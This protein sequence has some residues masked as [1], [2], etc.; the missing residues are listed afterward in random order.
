MNED[1]RTRELCLDI[2]LAVSRGEEHSHVLIKGVLDKYDDW[3]GSRKAFLKK[4]TMGVLERK[5]ELDYV[6]SRF[7]STP[8]SKLKPVIRTIL[9]IGIYQILY[10]DSV[11]DTKAVNLSVELAKKRGPKQLSGFVNGV[12]R[13]VSRQK[14][15]IVFP[16]KSENPVLYLS[17]KYSVPEWIVKEIAGQYG[18]ER[19]ETMFADSLNEAPIRVH[20]RSILSDGKKQ[21]LLEAW[22]EAGIEVIPCS[23][24]PDAYTLKNAESISGVKGFSEGYFQVQDF[25]S[26]LSG[27]LAPLQAGDLV[28]DVCAA[29]GGKSIY[30]ADK[31]E[32]LESGRSEKTGE[33]ERGRVFA[34]D[35]SG[36]KVGK[37]LENAERMRIFNISCE[38]RDASVANPAMKNKADLLIADV[39]CSGLGVIG[40][41]PD[42]KYRLKEQ[43]FKEIVELQKKI[44]TEAVKDVKNGGYFLY[45]TCTV[46]QGENIDM[47]RWMCENLPL[48][49]TSFDNL[50]EELKDS[51]VSKGCVQLISGEHDCDGFFISLL[52]RIQ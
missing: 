49:E 46:N 45:S 10:M 2:L 34:Y 39:P 47:V 48:E 36:S 9:E 16:E 51:L 18:E 31:L 22:K 8:V 50:P 28:V 7:S 6:I 17:V 37:I 27:Y 3:D 38:V 14:D 44:V 32:K 52:R 41:K 35:I 25:S 43:D 33:N 15:G 13:N 4:L 30:V 1:L 24:L 26:Q 12:L 20:M 19:A 5:V 29:P 11:Y 40:R 21:E 42:L 23:F